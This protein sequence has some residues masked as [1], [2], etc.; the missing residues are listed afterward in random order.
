M[1]SG[2]QKVFKGSGL[3]FLSVNIA[4]TV[5]VYTGIYKVK[6]YTLYC[7]ITYTKMEI[8][9]R[10]DQISDQINSVCIDKITDCFSCHPK[11][12]VLQYMEFTLEISGLGHSRCLI[13]VNGFK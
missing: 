10:L 9:K 3:S 7:C 4:P 2:D 11:N 12:Y 8:F 13:N 6:T 5:Y 1:R